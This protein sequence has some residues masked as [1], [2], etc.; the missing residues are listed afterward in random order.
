M[1]IELTDKEV[2]YLKTRLHMCFEADKM[3]YDDE[4]DEYYLNEM[5]LN[6]EIQRKLEED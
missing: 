3:A 1:V 4:G 6:N 5:E 2:Q